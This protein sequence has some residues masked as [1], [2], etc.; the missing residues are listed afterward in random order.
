MGMKVKVLI[1]TDFFKKVVLTKKK[2]LHHFSSKLF[3]LVLIRPLQ[4]IIF[5]KNHQKNYIKHTH[6][7]AELTDRVDWFCSNYTVSSSLIVNLSA[8]HFLIKIAYL[9]FGFE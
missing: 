4:K 8:K 2:Q 9:I 1:R 5:Q 7:F 6:T 3:E